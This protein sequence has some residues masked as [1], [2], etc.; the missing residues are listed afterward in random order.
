M[1]GNLMKATQ[2]VPWLAGVVVFVTGVGAAQAQT[3]A[4]GY[5]ISVFAA[6]LAG[7]SGADS[8]EV[9][10]NNVYVGYSNGT[11]KDGS[12]GTS[13]IA[14]YSQN[15]TLLASTQV[16]G[17]TD[18]LRYNAATNQIWSIQ[19]EDANT[20]L[21]L[22][23][24]GTLAKGPAMNLNSVNGGGGFDD[25][26]FTGGNTYLSAS[27]PA[28]SPNTS[29][30]IVSAT[31]NG[32][33]VLTTP[34]VLGN[35]SATPLNGNSP[36]TLN[37]QDPD[38]L[39]M[40]PNGTVVLTSQADGQLVFVKGIGTAGQTVSVL[41]LTN[42]LADDTVFGGTPSQTL[43]V[44]D[45][46]TNNIYAITGQFNPNDGYSA[47]QDASGQNGFV[48]L[49][50]DNSGNLLPIVTGLGN[51]GGEAFLAAVPE[52]STWAMMILGFA[53]IALMAYRRKSK[54]A[55]MAA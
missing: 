43:L 49:L 54:T 8:V 50:G 28:L 36:S 25:I 32:G 26:L 23:T 55:L 14:E 21:V 41:Q 4:P 38:S 13:T 52:P 53:G 20:N 44:A 16:A 33:S 9:I 7:T 24:P 48:G 27:N 15:G 40:T 10:G 42:A 12:A 31:I 6:G 30:A 3:A 19:N 35:A 2:I 47:A 1:L 37:L 45:K 46:N 29:P 34:V 18:G 17:H 39:S 51:P 22:I 5:S 11:P